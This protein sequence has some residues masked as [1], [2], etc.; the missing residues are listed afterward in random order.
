[1]DIKKGQKDATQIKA[2]IAKGWGQQR[3]RKLR[4]VAQ[5]INPRTLSWI[6]RNTRTWPI[7]SVTN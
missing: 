3:T 4:P 2:L 1:M 7:F 5:T 6:P